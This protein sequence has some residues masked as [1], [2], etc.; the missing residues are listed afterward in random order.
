MI[1]RLHPHDA[2]DE[3]SLQS[4]LRPNIKNCRSNHRIHRNNQRK[5]YLMSE[6]FAL[7][8]KQFLNENLRKNG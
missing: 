5:T 4:E 3:L 7:I 2:C 8:M 1:C 6:N